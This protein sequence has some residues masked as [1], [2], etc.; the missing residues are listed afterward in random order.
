MKLSFVS[1]ADTLW[2]LSS[3]FLASG[4]V[5]SIIGSGFL[6]LFNFSW[7]YLFL[8]L[9]TFIFTIYVVRS[10]QIQDYKSQLVFLQSLAIMLLGNHIRIEGI[11]NVENDKLLAMVLIGSVI[12]IIVLSFW[13]L[14]VSSNPGTLS[15]YLSGQSDYF[16]SGATSPVSNSINNISY[17]DDDFDPAQFSSGLN[18]AAY[19]SQLNGTLS[20]SDSYVRAR[21]NF[22]YQAQSKEEVSFSKNEVMEILNQQGNWWKVLKI[23]NEIGMAPSNYLSVID[24]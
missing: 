17:E 11:G 22:S 14:L 4:W 24:Q 19:S 21:A 6:K 18:N 12:Q 1:F 7:I 8:S 20:G 9:I 23:N 3:F 10:R 16:F 5:L 13:L 2:L 15:Y